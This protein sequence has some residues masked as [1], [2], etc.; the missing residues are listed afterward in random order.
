MKLIAIYMSCKEC[1]SRDNK[2]GFPINYMKLRGSNEH[3]WLHRSN[4]IMINQ[5]RKANWAT[6]DATFSMKVKEAPLDPKDETIS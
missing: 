1:Y 6:M 3:L 2:L 5:D 4:Q